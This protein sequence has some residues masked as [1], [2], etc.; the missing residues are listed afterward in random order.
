MARTTAFNVAAM[1]AKMLENVKLPDG[2]VQAAINKLVE[3]LDAHETKFFI[4]QGM[5]IQKADVE[6]HSIQ[7]D[8]AKQIISMTELGAKQNDHNGHSQTR[9]AVRIDQNTGIMTLVV[10][11]SLEEETAEIE[12]F[13]L[14]KI[15]KP[16]NVSKVLE[17]AADD[18][19]NQIET[20]FSKSKLLAK[21]LE[22]LKD[23]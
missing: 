6:A 19:E 16:V 17:T 13:A 12:T 14:E 1:R 3:K 21:T 18:A 10:G 22:V 7:I 20:I 5:V 9:V 15:E 4:H 23:E 11:E 8:A 2:M